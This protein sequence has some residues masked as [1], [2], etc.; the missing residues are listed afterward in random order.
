MEN[1]AICTRKKA[2]CWPLLLRPCGRLVGLCPT[3]FLFNLRHGHL[4][5]LCPPPSQELLPFGHQGL[6]YGCQELPKG[7]PFGPQG[8]HFGC[9]GI[10]YSHQG[11]PMVPKVLLWSLRSSLPSPRSFQSSRSQSPW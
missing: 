2:A 8:L 3:S 11:L 5:W 9:Q 4:G 10:P 1:W 7:L 6:P